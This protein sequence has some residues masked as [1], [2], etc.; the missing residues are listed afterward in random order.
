MSAFLTSLYFFGMDM[1]V[2]IDCD[3]THDRRRRPGLKDDVVDLHVRPRVLVADAA[4]AVALDQELVLDGTGKR[5]HTR[6]LGKAR[7]ARL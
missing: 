4:V 5:D 7:V 2:A 6:L 1:T 3:G